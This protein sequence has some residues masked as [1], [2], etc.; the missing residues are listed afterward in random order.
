[1][2]T[3]DVRL[4]LQYLLTKAPVPKG[5]KPFR[6]FEFTELS[7]LIATRQLTPDTTK[8]SEQYR[9][10]IRLTTTD[11]K[12]KRKGYV[13]VMA[14]PTGMCTMHMSKDGS[15][16]FHRWEID[17]STVRL[18][19]AYWE[20]V[21][22][23]SW[24]RITFPDTNKDTIV[25]KSF[26]H[27]VSRRGDMLA[28]FAT[29]FGEQVTSRIK[30]STKKIEVSARNEYLRTL[31]VRY[32]PKQSIYTK[33]NSYGSIAILNPL[34]VFLSMQEKKE[35]KYRE[36]IL[37]GFTVMGKVKP[38]SIWDAKSIIIP[39]YNIQYFPLCL[40]INY[41]RHKESEL[42]FVAGKFDADIDYQ[43]KAWEFVQY[44]SASKRHENER[45]AY[46]V[47]T[48][49]L[50][51]LRNEAREFKKTMSQL[52]YTPERYRKQHAAALDNFVEEAVKT[53][54]YTGQSPLKPYESC[55]EESDFIIGLK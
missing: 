45:K 12:E 40:H 36:R 48:D 29:E 10:A 28:A 50:K 35:F 46:D 47:A 42:T 26:K 3:I 51:I 18:A 16:E 23:P 52:E 49:V 4:Y 30:W 7:H 53:V 31:A 41:G 1:M 2:T 19:D 9:N 38:E 14:I 33:F 22:A 21:L 43:I 32:Q 20:S 55:V 39:L 37:E 17:S 8:K 13:A 34:D 11:S 5:S 44:L 6:V 25:I 27:S 15:V 54:R 24:I